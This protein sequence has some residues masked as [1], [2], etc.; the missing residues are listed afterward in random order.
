MPK[1]GLRNE[2]FSDC[3]SS[4]MGAVTRSCSP[5]PNRLRFSHA[6]RTPK[7]V[8]VEYCK[9]PLTV[10]GGASRTVRLT[11]VVPSLVIQIGMSEPAAFFPV[12]PAGGSAGGAGEGASGESPRGSSEKPA[13][14]SDLSVHPAAFA[15]SGER[16]AGF[17]SMALNRPVSCNVV[18]YSF[19]RSSFQYCPS[20]HGLSLLR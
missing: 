13:S 9:P 16:R 6:P 4:E 1:A 7:P 5:P 3:E 10:R 8:S 2:A 17:I 18:L 19:N 15:C 20:I 12:P 14:A 11:G